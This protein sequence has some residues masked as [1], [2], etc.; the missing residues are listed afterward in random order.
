MPELSSLQILMES[1]RRM[2]DMY[3]RFISPMLSA[4][5]QKKMPLY[6]AQV[7]ATRQ[8]AAMTE[9]GIEVEERGI[10]LKETEAE[11]RWTEMQR[12]RDMIQKILGDLPPTEEIEPFRAMFPLIETRQQAIKLLTDILAPEELPSLAKE[13]WNLLNPEQKL[14]KVLISAGIEPRAVAEM[15]PEKQFDFWTNL[16][17]RTKITESPFDQWMKTQ[18]KMAGREVEEPETMF[19][20]ETID[21][22][23]SKV[24]EA[25]KN[26]RG[27]VKP[28]K[29]SREEEAREILRQ[30]GVIK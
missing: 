6:K 3:S 5:L 28:T 8:R 20:K 2:Q 7:E 16:L 27:V 1:Q 10:E 22:I 15:T 19:D 9:R 4:E 29:K 21:L 14:T 23:K 30:R 26:I 11:R 17:K 12:E 24:K 18:M 25:E 13:Q